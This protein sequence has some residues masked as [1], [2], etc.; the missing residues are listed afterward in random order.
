MVIHPLVVN[1]FNKNLPRLKANAVEPANRRASLFVLYLLSTSCVLTLAFS[2]LLFSLGI[3]STAAQYQ[4]TWRTISANS[5]IS[6]H[7]VPA[8]VPMAPCSSCIY[9]TLPH[10]L[11]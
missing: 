10:S 1:S 2:T 9:F 3:S 7:C 5:T 11:N 4:A 8:D 6:R